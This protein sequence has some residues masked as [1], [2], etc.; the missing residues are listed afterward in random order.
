VLADASVENVNGQIDALLATGVLRRLLAMTELKFSNSMIEAWWR[1][2]KHQWLFLHAFDSVATV[3][4]LGR[5][6][7]TS[8]TACCRMR[9]FAARRQTRCTR[10]RVTRPRLNSR[11]S[12][13]PRAEPACRPT[14][15]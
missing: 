14:D 4:R 5:S 11:R 12:R 6:T 9:R 13:T 7:S 8:T 15:Q 1:S 10:G 3:R 2:L